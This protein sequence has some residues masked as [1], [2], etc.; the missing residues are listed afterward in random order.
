M[1]ILAR[2]NRTAEKLGLLAA[3]L[4][5]SGFLLNCTRTNFVIRQLAD[6]RYTFEAKVL[7]A[8]VA[9]F[10]TSARL[11]LVYAQSLITEKGDLA[12][13][14]PYAEKAVSLTPHETLAWQL[15]G[16]AQEGVG[17][18]ALA[19]QSLRRAV[20]RAPYNS[21]ANWALANLLVRQEKTEEAIPF[22]QQAG[23]MN[24][25]LYPPAFDLLWQLEGNQMATLTRLAGDQFEARLALMQFFAE[26]ELFEEAVSIF[27]GLDRV[28]A[29]KDPT[30]PQFINTLLQ[31][32]QVGL[33]YQ[34]W[35]ELADKSK[36][37][38][39][40]IV[41]NGNFEA[42][43]MR[44]LSQ[45]DWFIGESKFARITIESGRGFNN[46]RA[47]KVIF[48]GKD[49]TTLSNEAFQLVVLQPH[50]RYRLTCLVKTANLVS[51]AGPKLAIKLGSNVLASS[52]PIETGTHDWQT[53]SVDFTTPAETY[54]ASVAVIRLPQYAYDEPTSGTVWFDEISLRAL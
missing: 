50:T 25:S 46:S 32:K 54:D 7:A 1:I 30:I 11:N 3:A 41:W 21:D 39:G 29:A 14:L 31:R 43:L 40:E 12:A 38:A 23:T 36:L 44:P 22:F 42:P 9:K 16:Q 37:P 19:E 15:L 18:A 2:L 34:A 24:A 6:V 5:V 45:F 10:P 53:I 26:Q 13:A 33:A 4:L 52:A 35:L 8:G 28:K 49:T 20:E 51:P 48:T 27:H 17:Q 47:L